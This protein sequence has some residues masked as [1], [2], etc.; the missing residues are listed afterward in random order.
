MLSHPT[1]LI[2]G[3][4]PSGLGA[5]WRLPSEEL[6]ECLNG[7]LE[8]QETSDTHGKPCNFHDWIMQNFGKGLAECFMLPYNRKVWAYDPTELDVGW[9]NQDHSL[10][11]GVEAIDHILLGSE[12]TTYYYP[13]LVNKA[14]RAEQQPIERALEMIPKPATLPIPPQTSGM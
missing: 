2:L 3:A 12:E 4:G 7:L 10:M 6:T 14:K 5:A 11:Q 9:S 13:S 8:I 1:I